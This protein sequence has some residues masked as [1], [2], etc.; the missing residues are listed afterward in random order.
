L[1][2]LRLRDS[3]RIQVGQAIAVLAGTLSVVGMAV[4]AVLGRWD[5]LVGSNALNL[6]S[7]GLGLA[8]LTWI[9]VKSQPRNG[10]VWVVGWASLFASLAT[11]GAGLAILFTQASVPGLTYEVMRGLAPAELSRPAAIAIH[12]RFWALVPA[13][14]LPITLGLLLFPDGRP[15]TPRWR[16]VGWWSV[17]AITLA[18]VA[19]AL[20]Q[21]P[22]STLPV[23]AADGSIDTPVGRWIDVGMELAFLSG[24][25]SAVS[26]FLRYRRSSGV[27]RSQ[28]R[29]LVWGGVVFVLAFVATPLIEDAGP[30][31]WRV[32]IVGIVAETVLIAAYG[33]A[34]MRYRLYDIDVVINKTIVYGSLVAFISAVFA[35]V[36]FVPF[37][38]IGAGE[39]TSAG[40]LALPFLATVV[41][42]VVFQPVR[43]RLQRA[44]DRL[45]YGERASPYEAL[46]AFSASVAE[47]PADEELLARMAQILAEA[48]GATEAGVW[49]LAG[50]ELRLA[51]V[52]PTQDHT[53]SET[54]ALVEGGLPDVPGSD[55]IVEVAYRG[56][57]LGA[58]SMALKPGEQ[59]RPIEERLVKDL[60]SNAGVV[61]RNFRLTDELLRR[62]DELR[63]S[64]QRL[65]AAQDEERRRIERNLHDGA[66][67]QLVALKIK[68]GLLRMVEDRE[69]WMS[70]V[71][72]L[73][74]ETDEAIDNLRDFA[75]GIYPPTLAQEGL[76]T[77]LRSQATKAVVPTRVEASGIER[78]SPDIEAAVYFCT[79]EAMQNIVKYANASAAWVHLSARNGSLRFDV[80]DDGRGFDP[81]TTKTGAGLQN[82]EDRLE[83]LGGSIQ[84]TST[85]GQGTTI[86]GQVPV[87][88][89]TSEPSADHLQR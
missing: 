58:L 39:T 46:S 14:T 24:I 48:T 10:A 16:W 26:L 65:V 52:Y 74:E 54:R 85:P 51:A 33:I 12:F 56:E 31:G 25:A 11:A 37:L 30:T 61:F 4:L 5:A 1:R 6:G 18:T 19:T 73:L 76:V 45:V 78:Y 15:L 72:A 32:A 29:W 71:E 47:S 84:I 87:V 13:I 70:L 53:R 89:Q 66:Q 22:W 81:A 40:D 67:Q 69:K 3:T 57:L 80:S 59:L 43:V 75:R 42:V 82:M 41:L 60:A 86:A 36:V 2:A 38:V 49:V 23:S 17:L 55:E 34:I 88:A 7:L 28:I 9:M 64:R 27:T 62:L 21:T 79:L 77:A 8:I 20:A 50:A 44:A 63:A 68:L 83:A 35:A